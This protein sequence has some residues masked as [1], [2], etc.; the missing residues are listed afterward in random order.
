MPTAKVSVAIGQEELAW[1]RSVA[2]REGKSLSAV[3]TESLAE[4]KRLS[5]LREVV[6][7]MGEGSE[8][9][10][11]EELSAANRE[12]EAP[13]RPRTARGARSRKTPARRRR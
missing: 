6:A 8:P 3:L 4:R 2:R 5:A 1:A 7:W 10:S 9:L 13:R 12:L 11:D